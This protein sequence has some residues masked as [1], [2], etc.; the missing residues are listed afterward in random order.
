MSPGITNKAGWHQKMMIRTLL[1]ILI[2]PFA[3]QARLQGS[4]RELIL[5]VRS[6]TDRWW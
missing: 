6:K 4:H 5:T 2:S 3:D 1:L